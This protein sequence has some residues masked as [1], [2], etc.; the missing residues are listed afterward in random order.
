MVVAEHMSTTKLGKQ[1]FYI[2]VREYGGKNKFFKKHVLFNKLNFN[3]IY[4]L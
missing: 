1:Y 4:S 3:I 2:D